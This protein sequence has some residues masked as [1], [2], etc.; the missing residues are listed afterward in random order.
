M[1]DVVNEALVAL[2]GNN[3]D[4]KVETITELEELLIDGAIIEPQEINQLIPALKEALKAS[5]QAL[6]YKALIT[7]SPLTLNVAD[8]NPTYLKNVISQF[9]MIVIDKLGDN[10]DKTR[11]AALKVLLDMWTAAGTVQANLGN[12]NIVTALATNIK[13]MAFGHKSWRVREQILQWVVASTK[14]IMDFSLRPWLPYMVKFLEDPNEQVRE[15]TKETLVSLFSSA[16]Q[17]AKADLKRELKNKNIRAATIDYILSKVFSQFNDVPD[18]RSSVSYDSTTDTP[19]DGGT[20]L[21][22]ED[23]LSGGGHNEETQADIIRSP[24]VD[25]S[26]VDAILIESARELEREFQNMLGP[27]QGRETEQNWGL[28]EKYVTRLRSLIRGGAFS[29]HSEQFMIGLKVMMDGI[30]SSVNS[31]RT[32]LTLAASGLVKDLAIYLG[33]AIDPFADNLLANLIKTAG[34]VK[35]LVAQ[36]GVNAANA[37]LQNTSYHIRLVNQ[38]WGAMQDKSVQ[39]RTYTIEFARCVIKSHSD[40]KETIE[41]TGG[42]ELLQNCLKK[43]LTDASPKVRE[44]SRIVFWEFY[45][46]WPER[47]EGILRNVDPSVKKQMEKEKPKIG[48]S[49]YNPTPSSPTRGRKRGPVSRESSIF[50]REPPK[51]IRNPPSRNISRAKS[52]SPSIARNKIS[53]PATST[54]SSNTLTPPRPPSSQKMY[55]SNTTSKRVPGTAKLPPRKLSI[56]EHLEHTDSRMRIEGLYNM[57]DLIAKRSQESQEKSEPKRSQLPPN[58]DLIPVLLNLLNDPDPKVIQT[59]LDEEVIVD[60]IKVVP[61]EHFIPKILLLA[62]DE[63]KTEISAMVLACLP[64]M[65][66]ALGDESALVALNKCLLFLNGSGTAPRKLGAAFGFTPPQRRKIIYGLLTWMNEII[67]PKLSESEENNGVISGYLGDPE[68][69]QLLTERLIPM[70][71]NI[72]KNSENFKPLSALLINMHKL[73]PDEFEKVLFTYDS[74]FVEAVGNVV[75]WEEELEEAVADELAT[76]YARQSE[77]PELSATQQKIQKQLYEQQLVQQQKQQLQLLQEEQQSNRISDKPNSQQLEFPELQFSEQE[78]QEN[79]KLELEQGQEEDSNPEMY[80]ELEEQRALEAHQRQLEQEQLEQKELEKRELELQNQRELEIEEERARKAQ[81]KREREKQQREMQQKRER[82]LEEKR[83]RDLQKKLELEAKQQLE[84]ERKKAQRERE[85]QEKRE[86]IERREQ[87]AKEQRERESQQKRERDAK[88]K[89]ERELKAQQEREAQIQRERDREA[90]RELEIQEELRERELLQQQERELKAQ[91]EIETQQQIQR[92]LQFHIEQELQAQRE[93]EFQQKRERDYLLQR[94]REDQQQRDKEMHIRD[95]QAHRQQ[96]PNNQPKPPATILQRQMTPP[97]IQNQKIS[98]DNI[99]DWVEKQRTSQQSPGD[100]W[101]LR[102][103]MLTRDSDLYDRGRQVSKEPGWIERERRNPNELEWK[104]NIRRPTNE[105]VEQPG[106]ERNFNQRDKNPHTETYWQE[107]DRRDETGRPIPKDSRDQDWYERVP[108]IRREQRDFDRDERKSRRD[109]KENESDDRVDRIQPMMIDSRDYEIYDRVPRQISRELKDSE[110]DERGSRSSQ[111]DSREPERE[112]RPSPRTYQYPDWDERT[113]RPIPRDT[114]KSDWDDRYSRSSPGENEYNEGSV[115]QPSNVDSHNNNT[116]NYRTPSREGVS[117]ERMKRGD[118]SDYLERD[119]SSDEGHSRSERDTIISE[120]DLNQFEKMSAINRIDRKPDFPV[121]KDLIE[122]VDLENDIPIE[123]NAPVNFDIPP[124]RPA[125]IIVNENIWAQLEAVNGEKMNPFF[126]KPEERFGGGA[127]LTP[128]EEMAEHSEHH[129]SESKLKEHSL[130]SSLIEEES[131]VNRKPQNN[132]AVCDAP[133][134]V[135][136][137]I[138]LADCKTSP[139][140]GISGD[141]SSATTEQG[142]Q[143]T[144]SPGGSPTP[145][146]RQRALRRPDLFQ[147]PSHVLGDTQERRL[148]LATL[149]ARLNANADVDNHL[150]RKL[151]HLSKETPLSVGASSVDIWENGERFTELIHA[152]LTFLDDPHQ[153][154]SEFKENALSLL[155]QLLINQSRYV[156]GLERDIL[157]VLLECRA[158]ISINVSGLADENLETYVEIVETHVGLYALIDIME[159]SL[160]ASPFGKPPPSPMAT[161]TTHFSPRISPKGSA[162]FVLAKL[163]KRFDKKSLE[164]QIG[165]IVPLAIRG[166]NDPKPEIR[167]SV[168]E[169][170]VSIYSVIGDDSTMLQYLSSLNSSQQNLIKYYFK[171]A[172]INAQSIQV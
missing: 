3:L 33:P 20:E 160:L 19:I 121:Y 68:K 109:Y 147:A 72:K 126:I 150:F 136:T 13:E 149:L 171:R 80:F 112:G 102:E 36:A 120:L 8:N 134:N 146:A 154:N 106:I 42:V 67:Q 34:V 85:L 12:A 35:K 144:S 115:I 23:Y 96:L 76:E 44:G 57:Q 123:D 172:S 71:N 5:Q 74:K 165:R 111:R 169:A 83:Q 89:R 7:I 81:E 132:Y 139:T 56:I 164:R 119:G 14:R 161:S 39:V 49:I 124:N 88:L 129:V 157:R 92:E 46:I 32:T 156:K 53:I 128:I 22:E 114:R 15:D 155:Q 110:S 84:R 90:Q 18:D 163:V 118:I 93:L 98:K 64:N 145:G 27:F 100:S 37:L 16:S 105:W 170:L 133:A 159:S 11:E 130:Q 140:P 28:R 103:K 122:N 51:Q 148:L 63:G 82:D 43:G 86:E 59:L 117:N 107:G 142:S 29:N 24:T 137:S 30:L 91:R 48:I 151:S 17:H 38:I 125:S 79:Q 158:D 60:I 41:R 10:K 47:G 69:Y 75:G 162:F 62:G 168:V 54:N 65:K 104:E 9:T 66:L 2:K 141:I 95:Y 116:N 45:E 40:R 113:G 50:V 6:S 131:D 61:L 73:K 77:E 58:E 70:M 55:L 135:I 166:F 26:D 21:T 94:E 31:L 153:Q 1:T 25:E 101:G 108:Q 78:L 87:E 52:P 4:K 143:A 167:K 152:L 97:Y 99:H 138:S 127:L